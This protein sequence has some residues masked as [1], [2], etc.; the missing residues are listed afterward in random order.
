MHMLSYQ[1]LDLG[2]LL[3]WLNTLIRTKEVTNVISK[4]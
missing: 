4:L 2:E 3:K 1:A